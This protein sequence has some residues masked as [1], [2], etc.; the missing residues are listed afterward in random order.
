MKILRT[1]GERQ[2]LK[3]RKKGRKEGGRAGKGTEWQTRAAQNRF[4]MLLSGSC[5]IHEI[6]LDRES[7]T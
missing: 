2:T 7:R 1:D 3:A 6:R 5:M 4:K